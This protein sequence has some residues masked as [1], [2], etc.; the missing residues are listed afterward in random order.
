MILRAFCCLVGN[1]VPAGVARRDGRDVQQDA[2]GAK[3]GGEAGEFDAGF[4]PGR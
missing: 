3:G 1:P 4:K 2:D